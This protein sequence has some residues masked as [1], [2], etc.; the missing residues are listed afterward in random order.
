MW[1]SYGRYRVD[2]QCGGSPK[3]SKSV[4]DSQMKYLTLN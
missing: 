3:P 4:G 2:S 1:I